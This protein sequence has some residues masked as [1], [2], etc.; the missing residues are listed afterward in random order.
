MPPSDEQSGLPSGA[1]YG[2]PLQCELAC[3][4]TLPSAFPRFWPASR[5]VA[6]GFLQLRL[7]LA[8]VSALHAALPAHPAT[9][10]CVLR[11]QLARRAKRQW[12]L[13]PGAASEWLLQRELWPEIQTAEP[14]PRHS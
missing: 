4:R 6:G 11:R 3:S 9:V 13:R 14:A 8:P 1:S 12:Y 7:E 2:L 10:R 5:V